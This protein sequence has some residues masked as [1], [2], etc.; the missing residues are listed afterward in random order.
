MFAPDHNRTAEEMRRVCRPDGRIA[1]AC[2]TPA[3]AIGAMFE[4]LGAISPAP[5]GGFQPPVLWGTEDHVR[6]LLG[7]S[8]AFERHY[9][10]FN[11]PSPES[12]VD[13]MLTSFPPLIAMRAQLGDELV[14]ET[15]LD[16]AVDVNEADDGSLRYRGEY[17]V[18]VT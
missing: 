12:Y 2:W 15:Y 7:D 10:D 8:I 13:F 14:R 5:P 18:S 9:V 17:L 11:E 3:G 1:I 4:R 16:W 6:A